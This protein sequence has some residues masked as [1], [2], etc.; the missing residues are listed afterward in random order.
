VCDFIAQQ[1]VDRYLSMLQKPELATDQQ[2]TLQ[3]LLVEE[4]D[5]LARSREQLELAD[6]RVHDGKER[7]RKLKQTGAKLNADERARDA[8]LSL[9]ATMEA[10]QRLLEKFHRQLRDELYPFCIMLQNTMVGVSVSLDEAQQRAQ[11]FADANPK[12]VVTIIDR[13]S[14]DSDVVVPQN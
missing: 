14:G 7:I 10:T 3:K 8:N 11:Q 9:V 1:N 13:L 12:L 5:L 4:E 6:R 2:K